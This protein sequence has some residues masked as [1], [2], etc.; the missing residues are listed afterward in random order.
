VELTQLRYFVAVAEE[1]N[2]RRAAERCRVAQPAL[3]RRVKRLEE[4]LGV[5][6]LL[7]TKRE[8]RLTDAGE[9]FL[10][11]AREGL[12]R[13]DAG[14]REVRRPSDAEGTLS[15]GAVDYANFR[16]LPWVLRAFGE[17][18]PE[19]RVLR[20]D[21]PPAEQVTFLR[22]GKLDVGFFGAR[23]REKDLAYLPV[24]PTAWSVALPTGHPLTDTADA[25]LAEALAGEPLVLFPRYANPELYDWTVGR[26]REA[27]GSEP[28]IVQEPTQLAGALDLVAAGLGLFPTPF[29]LGQA[30]PKVAVRELLGFDL[31]VEVCAVYRKKDASVLLQDFLGAVR[32][33]TA[34]LAQS[35]RLPGALNA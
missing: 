26:L 20:R 11:A 30:P 4:E 7:R 24:A 15:V 5:L 33:A 2:F 17:L 13:I 8:V 32:E 25:I 18:R 16:F 29:F 31:G 9:T 35:G 27:T 21:L 6:L 1:L 12:G 22:E 28:R 10:K 23:T 34:R 14:A 19:A 3:S